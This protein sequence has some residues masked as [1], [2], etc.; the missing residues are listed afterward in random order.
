MRVGSSGGLISGEPWDS[1]QRGEFIYQPNNKQRL[2]NDS[3]LRFK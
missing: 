2:K 1:I 3:A